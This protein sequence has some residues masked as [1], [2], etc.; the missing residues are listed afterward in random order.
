MHTDTIH[1]RVMLG[2]GY[3]L[4]FVTLDYLSF[5]E[6]FHGLAITP[7]NPPSGL[8]LAV[9]MLWGL[10]FAGAVMLAPVVATFLIR[11]TFDALWLHAIEALILGGGYLLAGLF[12]RGPA[13]LN[14]ALASVRDVVVLM[15]TAAV[16]TTSVGMAYIGILVLNGILALADAGAGLARFIVGDLVGIL[17]FTPPL[18]LL[19]AGGGAWLRPSRRHLVLVAGIVAALAIILYL[20]HASQFQLFYLLFIPLLWSA[21]RDGIAGACLA[22]TLTQLGLIAALMTDEALFADLAVFQTFLI[23]LSVIGLVVGALVSQQQRTSAR[24]RYQRLSLNR[25]LRVRSVG[26]M[27]SAVAHEVNQPITAI[28]MLCGV[29]E[30]AVRNNDHERASMAVARLRTECERA[31]TIVRSTRDLMHGEK[32]QPVQVDLVQAIGELRE[33][34]SDRLRDQGIEF[35]V[36]VAAEARRIVADPVQLQQALYN[37]IDNS[38]DAM[39]AARYSGEIT[40]SARIGRDG[41][42][43]VTVGDNGPGFPPELLDFG[44]APFVSTKAHGSGIGLSVARSIAE[45]HGGGL[46]FVPQASGASVSLTFPA[47][48][49]DE[50][51]SHY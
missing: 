14:P 8:A 27:A 18:L 7:W 41:L 44:V 24:L 12:L 4:A 51:R 10:R 35:A 39:S 1:T 13:R 50:H 23:S 48:V 29:V 22:L 42:V 46:S 36:S 6:S 40:V 17:V 49:S 9:T 25:A 45:A 26:E 5:V 15:A 16:A 11:E 28:N 32:P 20:P 19:F 34:V 30:S 38:I 33:L 21:L 37:L 3:V 2:A 43:E 47:W 31:G